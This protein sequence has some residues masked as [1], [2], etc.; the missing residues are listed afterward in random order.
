M[1]WKVGNKLTSQKGNDKV[2]AII[3][4][5]LVL[6]F[7][8]SSFVMNVNRVVGISMEPTFR[9]NDWVLVNRLA[10]IHDSPRVND[11]IIFHKKSVTAD[12]IIKRI[13]A[14]SGDE[15]EIK[16]GLLYING[17]LFEDDFYM[18]TSDE[19][20]EKIV[21]EEDCYFVLGDNRNHSHDSRYWSD[22]F[23]RKN[24]IIGKVFD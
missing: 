6:A 4:A 22:P 1:N 18:K 19:Y 14:V 7:I 12:I 5:S 16:K 9:E 10:Y 21:I 11:I 2:L 24:E 17:L 20:K 8:V 23:V 15:V 13:V 3:I